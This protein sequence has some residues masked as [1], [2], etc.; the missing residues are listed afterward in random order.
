M[1]TQPLARGMGTFFKECSCAKPTRCPHA[2]KIRYRNAAGKQTEESGFQTQDAAKDRL[3]EIYNQKRTVPQSK[4]ER[5]QT[6]GQ[7]RFEEYAEAWIQRRRGV[8]PSTIQDIKGLL[9]NHVY[10]ELG[11]R[12]INTFDSLVIEQYIA[13]MERN[14]LGLA[15]QKNSF[16]R[17]KSVLRDAYRR[18]AIPDDP[19]LDVTPPQYNPKRAIIPTVGELTQIRTAGDDDDFRLVVDLMS[20]CGLRNG[21]ALAVNVNNI[22]ADDVYRV[23]EQLRH[24]DGKLGKLKHRK[25]GEF[26]EVP[27]PR[28]TKDAIEKYADQHGV[29]E[30][31]YLLPS[32]RTGSRLM[33]HRTLQRLWDS[34]KES[35]AVP[36]GMTLYSLRHFFASNCLTNGIPITDVAEWMGHKKIEVTFKIY[37]H[38][39]PGSINTAAKILDAGLAA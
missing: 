37:R 3:T 17:L 16:T 8:V 20:G 24:E 2:Y 26:R 18:G 33:S 32:R 28:T 22:V 19:F 21:E 1:A 31:G 39:M 11:S 36:D 4:A 27:L 6:L 38:L 14:G 30:G 13:T 10:P 15:V 25:S 35:A 12:R 7:M 5:I 34:A 29:L 23:T 9:K